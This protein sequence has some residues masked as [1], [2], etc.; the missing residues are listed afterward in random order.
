[1]SSTTPR[2]NGVLP[3]PNVTN[4][5]NFTSIT[6]N[7]N[8]NNNN[9]NNDNNSRST[10]ST[11]TQK[12]S[13]TSTT[14]SG[15]SATSKYKPPKSK[16]VTDGLQLAPFARYIV[17]A[18]MYILFI[19]GVID[20]VMT[21]R[22]KYLGPG[23]YAILVSFLIYFWHFISDFN[24]EEKL[25][26]SVEANLEPR[27]WPKWICF[28]LTIF[29]NY[30]IQSILC[31]CLSVYLCFSPQTALGA[32]GFVAASVLYLVGF[33]RREKPKPITGII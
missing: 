27:G 10:S 2:L 5:N 8:N 20:L 29:A 13:S 1:M 7:N 28:P 24:V 6:I 25:E 3:P 21:Q 16:S 22:M 31:L 23:I 30:L 11:S 12:S 26:T 9:S 33:L 19:L 18:N 15:A 17:T 32:F 4:P 14:T